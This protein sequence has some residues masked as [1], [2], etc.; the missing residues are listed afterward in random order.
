MNDIVEQIEHPFWQSVLRIDGYEGWHRFIDDK[1]HGGETIRIRI[2]FDDPD[3]AVVQE[4][5]T[6]IRQRWSEIWPRIQDRTHQMKVAY[7]YNETQIESAESWFELKLPTKPIE[8]NAEWNVMLQADEAG[9]LLDF[10]GWDDA[11]GHG[12]F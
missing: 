4:N 7:G 10:R 11:G 9:W 3:D 2:E 8:Q 6:A 5:F 1:L 12:V